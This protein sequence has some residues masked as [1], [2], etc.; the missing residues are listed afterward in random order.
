M[1]YKRNNTSI[2]KNMLLIGIILYTSFTASA[3]KINHVP[4]PIPPRN[5]VTISPHHPLGFEI[6][7]IPSSR[8]FIHQI[9]IEVP[10]AYIFPTHPF[11][12]GTNEQLKPIRYS[13][14]SHI[15]Y[16]FRF[17]PGTY[18]DRIYGGAYQ[19]IGIACFYFQKHEQLGTPFALYLF[20]GARITKL[21]PRLAFNYEWNFGL[22][23]GWK[24]YNY[25]YNSYNQI[26]GSKLN[27]YLNTGFYL[28]WTLSPQFELNTGIT[29]THFSNGNTNYPNAGLNTAGIKFGLIY[30][31]KKKQDFFFP[32]SLPPAFHRHI[33]YDLVLFGSWRKKGVSWEGKQVASPDTYTVMGFNFAPM[34]N[35]G[36]KVRIGI[37]LDGVY[38]GSANVYTTDYFSGTTQSFSKPPFHKQ[39]ALGTSGRLEYVMPY[40]TVGIGMG[41]NLI[42]GGGDLR[43]FYQ[44]LALKTEIT[45]NTFVHIGYNLKNF[46]TPNFLMLGVGIRFHNNYPSCY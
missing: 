20:Q 18:A 34:Y 37:S 19:G 2:Q 13:L 22:S 7:S 25:E 31:F 35:L 45:R 8:R 41:I 28:N 39:L 24:P 43:A 3:G 33:S 30:N 4:S 17:Q 42:H 29:L 15:K 10:P 9:G 12:R 38:D 26:I 36:Y 16:S 1:D 5:D 14:S 44:I 46:E 40:F 11:L 23:F 32:S 27:A 21:T 6:D